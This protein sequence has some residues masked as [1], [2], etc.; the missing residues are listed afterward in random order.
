M[1]GLK[2]N[3]IF[4]VVAGIYNQHQ[5]QFGQKHCLSLPHFDNIPYIIN[6]L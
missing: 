1:K 3:K 2:I 5:G 6:P 4:F